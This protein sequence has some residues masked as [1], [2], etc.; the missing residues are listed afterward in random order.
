MKKVLFIVAA[1]LTLAL[2]FTSCKIETSEVTVSVTD[3]DGNPINNREVYYTDMASVIIAGLTPDPNTPVVGPDGEYLEF[4]RTN[5]QGTVTF[6]FYLGVENLDYYF[7]VL[8][9]G[10]RQWKDATVH[11]KRGKNAEVSFKL[12]K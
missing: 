1:C 12:N 2:G 10:S 9:E 8:D 3:M 6:V 5:A 7:Y 11:L 4:G